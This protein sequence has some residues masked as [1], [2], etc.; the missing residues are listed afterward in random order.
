MKT[1]FITGISRG[2]GLELARAALAKGDRVIGTVRQGRP[3]LPSDAGQLH[4]LKLDTTDGPAIQTT[5]EQA[6]ALAGRIDVIV[7]NAGYGQLGP[8]EMATDAEVERVFDVDIIG[9]IRLL[10]AALPHLRAQRSGHILNI[11]SI[12]GRAPGPGS[13]LYA[14]VKF[15][16]EGLSASLAQEVTPFGVKVTAVAPGAFR[17]DFLST[18][19]L[20]K[21]ELDGDAYAPTVGRAFAAFDAMAGAQAGDPARAA[22]AMIEI[23]DAD[24]PPLHLLLGSDAL[25][26]AREQMDATAKDMDRWEELTRSTDFPAK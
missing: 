23:V 2:F 16:L 15:A 21:S 9:P 14:A 11:T 13:A 8:L 12:A 6:F 3:D 26:R 25:R 10:R 18:H 19:S 22:R 20:R 5:V 1:W 17:T 4:V 24:S 7:N